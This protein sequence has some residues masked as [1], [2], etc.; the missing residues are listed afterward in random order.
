MATF[1]PGDMTH[2]Q[3]G[4]CQPPPWIDMVVDFDKLKT[5]PGEFLLSAYCIEDEEEAAFPKD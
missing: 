4:L 3:T 2:R 5:F 1:C